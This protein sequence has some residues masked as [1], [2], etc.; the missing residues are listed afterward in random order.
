MKTAIFVLTVLFL[1]GSSFGQTYKVLWSFGGPP[2]DGANPEGNLVF[3]KA[4]NLYGTTEYGGRAAICAA[5]G[6]GTAF[7]LSP[8]SNGSWT[9][10]V[11]YSFCS[12][13]ENSLCLDGVSPSAGLVFDRAGNLYGTTSFGGAGECS[14]FCGTVFELSPPSTRGGNWSETVLYS[15]CTG[16]NN[17]MCE[18]G[19]LPLSRLVFDASGN[20]YGTTAA[21]GHSFASDGTAFE[22]S[23]SAAGWTHTTLYEFCSKGTPFSCPDGNEPVAGLTFDN[24]G[25]LYGTTQSGGTRAGPGAGSIFELSPGVNGWT[26]RVLLSFTKAEKLQTP[27]GEVSFDVEGNLY[28]TASLGESGVLRLEPKNQT[29]RT[30][31]FSGQDGYGPRAGVLVG[32]REK[33]IYGTTQQGGAHDYG[34]VFKIDPSGHETVLY[35][36]CQQ[37]NCADGED[38][39]SGLIE[40]G[41]GNLYGTTMYGGAN[42]AGVVFEITP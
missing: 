15:F 9:E 11:L 21:G 29:E 32:R 12:V 1:C 25:N 38:P 24:S 42:N 36:F 2:N 37:A 34:V 41:D 30:Y 28:S 27:T 3:G 23:P 40:D 35:S 19:V 5:L 17:F 26:E 33:F 39:Y 10:S 6:C 7:E 18:D 4:G 14:Y 20:L 13:F 22:L 31:K 8:N 16:S